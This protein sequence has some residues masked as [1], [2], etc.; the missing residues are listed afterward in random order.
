MTRLRPRDRE[1]LPRTSATGK[2]GR[3]FSLTMDRI[4]QL[5]G[6]LTGSS[7][8]LAA[9]QRKSPDDVVITMAIRSVHSLQSFPEDAHSLCLQESYVQVKEGRL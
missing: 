2:A 1:L 8:G 3:P 5:A 7:T 4:K 6:H 9:L